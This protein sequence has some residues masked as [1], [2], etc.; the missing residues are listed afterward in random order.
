MTIF[1]LAARPW[2]FY[3]DLMVTRALLAVV[4][5]LAAPKTADACVCDQ[6]PPC[7]RFWTFDAVFT[8]VA[9]SVTWSDDRT[10]SHTTIVVERG[11][12]GAICQVVL[13]VD[14]T[15]RHYRFTVAAL[16]CL[17]RSPRLTGPDHQMFRNKLV[18]AA[19]EIHSPTTFLRRVRWGSL[20]PSAR[21]GPLD[22]RNSKD[23]F[24]PMCDYLRDSA[25]L[26][27]LRTELGQFEAA[28]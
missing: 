4:I 3:P 2:S 1:G 10:L 17:F 25:V 28:V 21:A 19:E 22:R 27:S 26:L 8:G 24:K 6:M 12:R 7:Q 14:A 18:A 13:T 23:I 11:L 15:T 20:R 9:T 5:L 16:P